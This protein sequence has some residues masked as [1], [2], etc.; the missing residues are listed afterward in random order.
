MFCTY[1][2]NVPHHNFVKDTT[3]KLLNFILIKTSRGRQSWSSKQFH[4]RIRYVI[5]ALSHFSPHSGIFTNATFHLHS[6]PKLLKDPNKRK[7][8]DQDGVIPYDDNDDETNEESRKSWKDYFDLIFGKLSTNDIDSFSR[9]YKMSDEEEKDVL[10]NYVK[11]K[12]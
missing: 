10:D 12:G 1:L 9:K 6:Q 5:S 2:R 11:F 7:Q 3:N 4:G 8:Y